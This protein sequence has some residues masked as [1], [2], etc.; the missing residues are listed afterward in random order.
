M[1]Q[2]RDYIALISRWFPG[3]RRQCRRCFHFEEHY[4]TTF[5]G[6]GL[7][8]IGYCQRLIHDCKV[9]EADI[10]RRCKPFKKG[11]GDF[12]KRRRGEI[13]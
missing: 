9:V 7:F 11:K 1:K 12:E 13:I 4:I 3:R 5:D 10:D 2:A 8:R 6:Q